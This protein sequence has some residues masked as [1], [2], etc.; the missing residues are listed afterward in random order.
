[1]NEIA[2]AR[3]I[4]IARRTYKWVIIDT[5]PMLDEVAMAA[6][7]LCDRVYVVTSGSVPTVRGVGGYLDL[8]TRVGVPADRIRILWN[9]S[10]PSFAGSLKAGDLEDTLGLSLI[11][12]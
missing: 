6:L 12:I 10:R 11:H 4:S 5:F 9:R 3:A 8:L 1:M 7:D 2:L